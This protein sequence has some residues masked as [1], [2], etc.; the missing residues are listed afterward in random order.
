MMTKQG[1]QKYITDRMMLFSSEKNIDI[2]S[3]IIV[4]FMKEKLLKNT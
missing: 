3:F 4:F 2:D 1:D